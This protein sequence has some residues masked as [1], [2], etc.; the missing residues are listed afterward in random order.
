[1]MRRALLAAALL[2]PAA[3]AQQLEKF[4]RQ[5]D[6]RSR[7]AKPVKT[8]ERKADETVADAVNSDPD[9]D[10]LSTDV[11]KLVVAIPT[12]PFRA[13]LDQGPQSLR[14][15]PYS[16][17]RTTTVQRADLVFQRISA[18]VKGLGARYSLEKE[19][20]IG[21]EGSWTSYRERSTGEDLHHF[22]A[23]AFA[24]VLRG[25]TATGRYALGLA[26]L[27]G[28]LTRVG[29]RLSLGGEWRPL[30]PLFLE[31]SSGVT[32]L[33]GGALGDFRVAAGVC[34]W[35]LQPWIGYRWLVGPLADLSGPEAGLSARF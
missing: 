20:G 26:G 18:D 24:D 21:F 35:R 29:P 13:V 8:V 15:V 7:Q 5:Y 3:S 31:A 12:F 11:L 25:A 9:S 27:S 28:R 10:N 34:V 1:M 22:E 32:A 17:E 23:S 2:A 14:T 4:E 19:S 16:E 33:E 6:G 30:K